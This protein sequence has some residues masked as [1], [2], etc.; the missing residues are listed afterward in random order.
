M[1]LCESGTGSGIGMHR[2]GSGTDTTEMEV[3]S[4]DQL[5]SLSCI[6]IAA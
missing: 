6:K 5:I 2:A 4:A 1:H 3:I